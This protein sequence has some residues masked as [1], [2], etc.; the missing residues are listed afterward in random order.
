MMEY[1]DSADSTFSPLPSSLRAVVWNATQMGF[2]L[3]DQVR[4]KYVNILKSTVPEAEVP[5]EKLLTFQPETVQEC[6]IIIMQHDA[7]VP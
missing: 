2:I 6:Y 4:H 3:T 1:R 5:R 7:N